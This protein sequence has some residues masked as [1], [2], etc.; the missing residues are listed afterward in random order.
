MAKTWSVGA[1]LTAA[2]LAVAGCGQ[3]DGGSSAPTTT[4]TSGAARLTDEQWSDYEAASKAFAS[5]EDAAAQKLDD[6]PVG[7]VDGFAACAGSSLDAAESAAT[8]L[9]TTLNSF[10][11][12][13]SG[14]CGS[15]LDALADSVTMYADVVTSV[16]DAVDNGN[17]SQ[18]LEPKS[19]L[20]ALDV[21]LDQETRAFV[22]ACAPA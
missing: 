1:A 22:E 2:L 4:S 16:Q 13:V 21:T 8:G 9:S 19:S 6:C 12:S 10:S 20:Q 5:S 18:L 14:P 17:V 15:D 11:G 3:S 7:S